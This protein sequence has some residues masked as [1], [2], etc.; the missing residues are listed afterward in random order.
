MYLNYLSD[1]QQRVFVDSAV[2]L[3]R[4]DERLA[5]EEEA[6]LTM[7][8]EELGRAIPGPSSKLSLDEA[9]GEAEEVYLEPMQRNA[10]MIELAAVCVIDGEVH[11]AEVELLGRFAEALGVERERLN[12]M[13]KFA[14]QA[15]EFEVIGR[16]LVEGD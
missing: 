15:R 6:L 2:L 16:E 11:V 5:I 14:A 8:G 3:I 9:V 13:V 10:F 4:S 12:E 1:D 7:I